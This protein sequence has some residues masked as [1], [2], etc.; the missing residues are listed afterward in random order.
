MDLAEL[1]RLDPASQSQI[2]KKCCGADGWVK[3]MS[4]EFPFRDLEQL[5][6]KA[7]KIWAGLG[8]EEYLEA[9]THHPRIGDVGAI[10]EKFK[11]TADWAGSEQGSVRGASRRIF[12]ELMHFNERYYERF[13]YIFIVFA[14]GKT[15]AEMLSLLKTRMNNEADSELAVA[16]AEQHKITLH[17]LEKTLNEPH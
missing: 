5:K 10:E 14:S 1:N 13:G 15:A 17:R 4:A 6:D 3:A 11:D 9:F 12:E 7:G 16:A 8:R 2:L